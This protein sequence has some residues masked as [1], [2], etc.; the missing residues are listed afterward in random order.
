MIITSVRVTKLNT[1][2]KMKAVATVTIDDA[3]AVHD[4]KVIEGKNGL[5]VAMP[6]RKDADGEY[7]DIVHPV[8]AEAR[9][10]LISRVL[11]EYRRN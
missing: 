6:N 9:E 2:K 5:F 7:K 3:F 1:E 8:S 4:I 11:D 10:E